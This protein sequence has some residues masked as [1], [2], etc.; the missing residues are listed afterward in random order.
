MKLWLSLSEIRPELR[1]SLI[2]RLRVEFDSIKADFLLS[3]L[4]RHEALRRW[5]EMHVDQRIATL[6][7]SLM[8]L[9][10]VQ[11]EGR[12]INGVPFLNKSC[13]APSGTRRSFFNVFIFKINRERSG[14]ETLG[15]VGVGVISILCFIVRE[16]YF[17]FIKITN[18]ML[19][20]IMFSPA[21]SIFMQ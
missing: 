13:E 6:G 10:H 19:I 9:F 3:F 8:C 18:A 11:T 21:P 17:K 1:P 12:R 7:E 20:R 14:A 2:C 5:E 4:S 16:I 15:S